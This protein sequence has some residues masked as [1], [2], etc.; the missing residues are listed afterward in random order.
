VGNFRVGY[1]SIF[2]ATQDVELIGG[3]PRKQAIR[4]Y[5]FLCSYCTRGAAESVLETLKNEGMKD[6]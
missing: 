3:R 6:F 4:T 5:S 2:E 1:V